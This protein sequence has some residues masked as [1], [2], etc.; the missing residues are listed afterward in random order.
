MTAFDPLPVGHPRRPARLSAASLAVA[1]GLACPLVAGAA[2][3]VV[4]N[5]RTIPAERIEAFVKAMVAQGRQDDE[6]LRRAVREELIAREL[7]VQEA[8]G[9][10]LGEDPEVAAQLARARQD[11]L[12]GALIRDELDKHPISDQELEKAYQQFTASQ[13]A[14]KEYRA[15]H[16]LVDDEAKAR[17]IITRLDAGEDFTEL[18]KVSLDPGSA[19]RG[20]DLEWNT[21]DTFVPEFGKAM[22]ALD[23]G[24]YTREPVKTQFGFHV[25]RLDD[26]RDAAPPTIDRL[27]TQL[28]QQLERDRVVAL[29]QALREK[30]TI[31]K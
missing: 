18:A 27:N 11:I 20:G 1:L 6:L 3:P 28:R 14:T 10:K 22:A 29:Q 23:K 19:D 24:A 7:F 16:I 17:E 9:R 4:V 21:P 15:S 25:I 8:E 2:E 30:A 5:G 12:I 13:A 26:V 31:G